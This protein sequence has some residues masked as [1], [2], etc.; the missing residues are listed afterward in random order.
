MSKS[1][2]LVALLL[3]MLLVAGGCNKETSTRLDYQM[4]EKILLGPLTYNV[5]QSTWK[6]ELGEGFKIRSPQQRF[7]LIMVSV[8]NGGGKEVA[9]P[10][11]SLENDRGQSIPE[12]ENPEGVP[13]GIGILR[14]VAPAQTL[15]GNLLFDTGL[16]SYKLK[17][18]DGGEPGAEKNAWVAI[19]LRMD[20]DTGVQAPIPGGK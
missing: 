12:S 10:L 11:F 16:A 20:V 14:T 5:I 7:L 4:G 3:P 6:N 8:T 13:N 17:L 18:T 2:T 15:Q 9:L 1:E 19:P